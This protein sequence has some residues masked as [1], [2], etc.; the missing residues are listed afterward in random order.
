MCYKWRRHQG[1]HGTAAVSAGWAPGGK[2]C[3]LSQGGWLGRTGLRR[4]G[5]TGLDQHLFWDHRYHPRRTTP[6][7]PLGLDQHVLLG[8]RLPSDGTRAPRPLGAQVAHPLE[9]SPL[10]ETPPPPCSQP[11]CPLL[12]PYTPLHPLRRDLLTFLQPAVGG[13]DSL[14]G[15]GVDWPSGEAVGSWYAANDVTLVKLV[16][17]YVTVT[18]DTA[19]LGE[20]VTSDTRLLTTA[21]GGA[22]VGAQGGAPG[23][24]TVEGPAAEG[25]AAMAP[26]VWQQLLG[27]ATAWQGRVGA[28]GGLADFGGPPNLLE[29]VPTYVHK[30]AAFNAA[31]VWSSRMVG[32]AA[33]HPSLEQERVRQLRR[34]LRGQRRR[35]K[36]AARPGL[37]HGINGQRGARPAALGAKLAAQADALAA[38]VLGL[39]VGRSGVWFAEQPDGSRRARHHGG[40]EPGRPKPGPGV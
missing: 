39:A 40:L 23:G 14:A 11:A 10:G 8:P 22:P 4:L 7:T 5:R 30:V 35:M 33:D 6:H 32:R 17:A 21:P 27:L 3:A 2:A 28:A 18:H 1:S 38:A 25:P 9:N 20:R 15:W 37:R 13:N 34:Q 19:F 29:C 36:A 31:A 26:T 16:H 12:P 24:A